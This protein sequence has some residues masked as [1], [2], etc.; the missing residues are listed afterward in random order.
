MY[1]A[2]EWLM[3]S[4]WHVLP[5]TAYPTVHTGHSVLPVH[6]SSCVSSQETLVLHL[7]W[8][9]AHVAARLVLCAGP[10]SDAVA[11]RA[12]NGQRDLNAAH[13]RRRI[14]LEP[15]LHHV[16]QCAKVSNAVF[17]DLLTQMSASRTFLVCI[18]ADTRNE[19]VLAA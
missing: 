10:G 12:Q 8:K 13:S 11:D 5:S 6:K 2:H 15:G 1:Q 3:L 7:V 19:P 17:R 9:R 4:V 14:I 16:E 18:S